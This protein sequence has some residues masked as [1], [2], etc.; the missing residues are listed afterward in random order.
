M[1]QW[2]RISLFIGIG[3]LFFANSG[4]AATKIVMT[5]TVP[6]T[7]SDTPPSVFSTA[8][9]GN[10]LFQITEPSKPLTSLATLPACSYTVPIPAGS[11]FKAGTVFAISISDTLGQWSDP[12]KATLLADAC[13]PL[14]KPNPPVVTIT[15]Q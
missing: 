9:V 14:P 8:E 3:L 12:G 6:T 2:A 10:Y 7:R 4:Y 1:P 13:N 5:C 15:V 11:C